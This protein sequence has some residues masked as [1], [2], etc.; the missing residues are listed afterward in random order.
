MHEGAGLIQFYCHDK[1]M[2]FLQYR[3]KKFNNGVCPGLKCQPSS[4]NT[5]NKRYGWIYSIGQLI[6]A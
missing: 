5:I 3:E 4:A 6:R 2:G 1:V